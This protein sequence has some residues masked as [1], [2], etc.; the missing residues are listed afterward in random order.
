MS[1]KTRAPIGDTPTN[2][3]Q[4]FSDSRLKLHKDFCVSLRDRLVNEVLAVEFEENRRIEETK[5]V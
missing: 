1:E 4:G 3:L 5:D 2:V